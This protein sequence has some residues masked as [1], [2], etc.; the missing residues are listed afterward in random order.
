AE[1]SVIP[2]AVDAAVDFTRLK[3]EPA[4]PTQGDQF[5]HVHHEVL[6]QACRC[7]N[8]FIILQP[9]QNGPAPAPF[10]ILL[11]RVD[12]TEWGVLRERLIPLPSRRPRH[13][14]FPCTPVWSPA[15][16]GSSAVIWLRRCWPPAVVFSLSMTFPPAPSPICKRSALIRT[17][18]WSSAA[19]TTSRG[20]P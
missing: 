16:R 18:T 2:E 4:P 19:S 14:L 10:T 20:W 13:S 1:R 12:G 7:P 3:D 8:V 6:L 11:R 17:C 5:V 15:G 9:A